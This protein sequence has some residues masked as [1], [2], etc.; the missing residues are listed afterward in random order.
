[1]RGFFKVGEEKHG[2][3][4]YEQDGKDGEGRLGDECDGMLALG[5]GQTL[6]TYPKNL[7]GGKKRRTPL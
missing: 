1:V 6:R 2:E 4:N 7:G 3:N 5:H